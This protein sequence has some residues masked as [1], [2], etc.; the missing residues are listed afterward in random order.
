MPIEEDRPNEREVEGEG[1]K[2]S[3]KFKEFNPDMND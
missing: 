2:Q 3:I 1:V